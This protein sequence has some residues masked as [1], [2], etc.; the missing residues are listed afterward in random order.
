MCF[1]F[2]QGQP[3]RPTSLFFFI[4]P[5][6][7]G[8]PPQFSSFQD[9][10]LGSPLF[11]PVVEAKSMILA[12]LTRDAQRASMCNVLLVI[13]RPLGGLFHG[14]ET[15]LSPRPP[16]SSGLVTPFLL[17]FSFL[18]LAFCMGY[19][20][21]WRMHPACSPQDL[22]SGVATLS[23]QPCIHSLG[24][25]CRGGG[26]TRDRAILIP[27]LQC[28]TQPTEKAG[29]HMCS[30]LSAHTAFSKY[31]G[32]HSDPAPPPAFWF[33]DDGCTFSVH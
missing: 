1:L 21:G 2:T 22:W 7:R 27:F 23:A 24:Q 11:Y 25:F 31:S 33:L 30:Q 17:F 19:G 26:R 8:R 4:L 9:L 6:I 18:F 29:L 10:N 32:K 16:F 5:L 20:G 3:P 12:H 15:K 14:R 13:L 28:S